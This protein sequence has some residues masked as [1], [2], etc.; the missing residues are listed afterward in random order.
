MVK[1]G[2]VIERGWIFGVNGEWIVYEWEWIYC[3][4]NGCLFIGEKEGIWQLGIWWKSGMV[5]GDV[6]GWFMYVIK[7]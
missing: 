2:C 5:M 3:G 4:C 1:Y 7:G 6:C